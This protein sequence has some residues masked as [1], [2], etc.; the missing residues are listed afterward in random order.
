MRARLKIGTGRSINRKRHALEI[1]RKRRTNRML[2]AM[3]VI[4]VVCWLPLN[5]IHMT[6]EFYEELAEW[7]GF[8]LT[9]FIAHVI[10]MSSTIYNPFLYAWMNENFQAEFR[11][12]LPCTRYRGRGPMRKQ[13]IS[14]AS[15]S[16]L[17]SVVETPM[18]MNGRKIIPEAL[19]RACGVRGL[20]TVGVCCRP[21]THVPWEQT[22][23]Q[24]VVRSEQINDVIDDVVSSRQA[25]T[26]WRNLVC[27]SAVTV[28][29]YSTTVLSYHYI[30]VGIYSAS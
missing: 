1:Y 8:L 6:L 26:L 10:A 22:E 18:Q 24:P 28:L 14:R 29:S 3:V 16:A 11:Q 4:S 15:V 30:T 27:L 23:M 25:V 13:Q 21:T 20:L 2:I 7:R 19:I 9:F 12:I 5:V 17:Y